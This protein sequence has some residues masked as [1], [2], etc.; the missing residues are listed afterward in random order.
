[1]WSPACS[2]NQAH[3]GPTGRHCR[4]QAKLARLVCKTRNGLRLFET[5]DDGLRLLAS[6]EK[7]GLKGIV[8][9][10]QDFPYRSGDQSEWI[11]VKCAAWRE[12]NRNRHELFERPKRSRR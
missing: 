4:P 2:P 7:M 10:R 6:C 11:K 5:F 9:K 8:S 12:A 1:L 3:A